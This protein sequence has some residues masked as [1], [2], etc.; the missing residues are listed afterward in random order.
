[1]MKI[2]YFYG[3]ECVPRRQGIFERATEL[4]IRILGFQPDYLGLSVRDIIEFTRPDAVIVESDY[5]ESHRL[6]PK[7]LRLPVVVCDIQKTQISEGF[8]G[9]QYDRATASKKAIEALFSLNLP[10]YAFAGYHRPYEWSRMRE[11]VFTEMMKAKGMAANILSFPHRKR[12]PD[13]IKALEK[14]L[15]S[16][17]CPCGILAVNDEI[18]DYVLDC[19]DRLGIAVP[20]SIAVIGVDNEAARCENIRP[21]LASVPPDNLHSGRLAVDLAVKQTER[22]SV[23][24]PPITYGAGTPVIRGSLRRFRQHDSASARALEYIRSHASDRKLDIGSVAREMG[25]PL[26]TARLHFQKYTGCS[27]FEEI[28]NQRFLLACT[29]L[30]NR[31]VKISSIHGACGYGCARA[32]R[33]VFMKRTG[34]TPSEWRAHHC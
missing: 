13:Y 9:I 1:M 26:S 11:D 16:L 33:N 7:D 30:Q 19:A 23:L 29:M 31:K 4:K 17:P 2:A 5:L 12:L 22:P 24:L 25:Q 15:L 21:P 14:W 27:I 20:D 10:N 6:S 18:G 28:E 32:V 3:Q 34:L 8:T